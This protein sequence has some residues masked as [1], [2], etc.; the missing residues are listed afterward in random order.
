MFFEWLINKNKEKFYPITHSDGVLVGDDK[1]TNVLN[2][3]QEKLV[4]TENIKTINGESILGSGDIE[5]QGGEGDTQL[6]KGEFYS[7]KEICV[8]RNINGKPLYQRT[9]PV[10][11]GNT[12]G[13]YYSE[14][15]SNIDYNYIWIDS[16]IVG[17][18]YAYGSSGYTSSISNDNFI[19]PYFSK[20]I[21]K[22]AVAVKERPSEYNYTVYVTIKYSKTTDTASSPIP[23][24]ADK[25]LIKGDFYSEDEKIIGRWIDNLPIYSK[26]MKIEIESIEDIDTIYQFYSDKVSDNIK[27]AWI[28]DFIARGSNG[29]SSYGI[30]NSADS[31]KFIRTTYINSSNKI[32]IIIKGRSNEQNTTAYVTINYTKTTDTP[33]TPIP[34]SVIPS[35]FVKSVECP[36]YLGSQVLYEYI[37]SNTTSRTNF[38]I[39][40]KSNDAYKALINIPM[41]IP[42]GYKVLCRLSASITTSGE[43]AFIIG[44]NGVDLL[45][46]G[47]W[48]GNQEVLDFRGNKFSNFFDLAKD[49]PVESSDKYNG[50]NVFNIY[51]KNSTTGTG[52]AR[53]ITIHAY[54]VK[55]DSNGEYVPKT[56]IDADKIQAMIN[57][58]IGS[59]LGGE[60]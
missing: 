14:E 48:T 30:T 38:F 50:N 47:G 11:I 3:K 7:D 17:S 28:T 46:E 31:N 53:N 13:T 42:D 59:V 5:I 15:L 26:T 35:L 39:R 57:E 9:L 8:G 10:Q 51:C 54:L 25:L 34:E 56:L 4:S 45:S 22:V 32:C 43:N 29:F 20:E 6:I 21:N 41:T 16:F 55:D 19:R 49:F 2:N 40:R 27:D 12:A 1:L 18:E 23:Q 33:E 24:L 36:I 44:I 60:F 58:S 37:T 52:W